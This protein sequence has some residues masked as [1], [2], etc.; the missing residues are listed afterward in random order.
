[1]NTLGQQLLGYLDMA[2]MSSGLLSNQ[3]DKIFAVSE[4]LDALHGRMHDGMT[5]LEA[6]FDRLAGLLSSTEER[7]SSWTT[8]LRIWIL[9]AL[10]GSL[11]ATFSSVIRWILIGMNHKAISH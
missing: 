1:V 11:F 6:G 9:T 8:Y 2:Q 4:Q 5:Y 3:S 7:I 10:L